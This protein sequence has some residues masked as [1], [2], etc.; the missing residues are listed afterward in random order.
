MSSRR[1]EKRK[2]TNIGH[3]I[4]LHGS[5][6]DI[7]ASGQER[8]DVFLGM[9]LRESSFNSVSYRRKREREKEKKTSLECFSEGETKTLKEPSI[10]AV[11][12]CSAAPKHD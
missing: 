10:R 5:Q 1:K 2:E 8:N 11:A 4:L 6:A 9:V 12:T 7:R 3:L